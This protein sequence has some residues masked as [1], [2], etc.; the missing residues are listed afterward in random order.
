MGTVYKTRV[1]LAI[2]LLWF[3]CHWYKYL[4]I[5]QWL[6]W[7]IYICAF[8]CQ[9]R[10]TKRKEDSQSYN[11]GIT[12][13]SNVLLNNWMDTCEVTRGGEECFHADAGCSAGQM[14]CFRL[15]AQIWRAYNKW[16]R[17][18]PRKHLKARGCSSVLW[19]HWWGLNTMLKAL[20]SG[21]DGKEGKVSP[22]D[23]PMQGGERRLC[24]G[25]TKSDSEGGWHF[26]VP[27]ASLLSP[28]L[29]RL[30]ELLK[31]ITG[32]LFL[33]YRMYKQEAMN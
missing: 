7:A 27:V 22:L 9:G 28:A 17:C 21:W 5:A 12:V 11:S 25:S 6:L 3:Q 13:T 19:S 20:C 18:Q 31:G 30:S 33:C 2:L 26:C 32:W 29:V 8:C 1:H 24:S 10:E 15:L 16:F 14:L 23:L 4:L